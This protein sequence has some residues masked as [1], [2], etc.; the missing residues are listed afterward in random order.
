MHNRDKL[1][2]VK[3]KQQNNTSGDL[4][5]RETSALDSSGSDRKLIPTP[6]ERVTLGGWS[7]R[8]PPS[9]PREAAALPLAAWEPP[10][11]PQPKSFPTTPW[12]GGC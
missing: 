4:A 12:D 3:N 1:S 7:R 6:Q 2:F 10:H 5:P 11:R 8:G 9:R